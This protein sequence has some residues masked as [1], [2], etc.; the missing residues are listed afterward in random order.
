MKH[1]YSV[2]A[3]LALAPFTAVSAPSAP[4]AESPALLPKPNKLTV[5]TGPGFALTGALKVQA[6][7]GTVDSALIA[8]KG[9]LPAG[10]A[11]SETDKNSLSISVDPAL[12]KEAY[13]LT[14]TPDGLTLVAGDAAGA[15]YGAQTLIQ[16]VVKDSAGKPAI[17]AMT[18]EDRPRFAWRGLMLDSCRHFIKTSNVKRMIDVMAMYKFNTLHWHLT[19]DQGWR[20][21]IKKYPKLTEIGSV[22]TESPLIG[23]RNKGDGKPYGPFF[24]T[25]AE[26]KDIVAYAKAR[27]ITII[28]EIE[29]PGHA[30]AAIAAYPDLGNNDLPGFN[31]KLRTRWGVE[32]YVYA[33]KEET[34]KFLDDVIGEV[35]S[36]FPDAPYIHIGGDEC[37]K[38]QW[39]K[40]PFA[41]KVM[42]DNDLLT[43]GKPDPHKLQSWF[44]RRVEKSI[45]AHGKKL[46]GWDEIQEGGLSPTA[47]MMVWRD[48]KW[49]TEAIK[50]GNDVVMT[51]GTHCYLDHAPGNLPKDPAFET[52][53][54]SLTLE[55]V[56]S[57]NPVPAGLTPE[58]AK[59]VIGVQGN[60]WSEYIFNQPKLEFL[61]F[62]RAI[63]LAEVGWTSEGR[64]EADFKKRLEK[65][66]PRL[67]AMK[68]NYQKLDGT[69]AQPDAKIETE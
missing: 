40:S 57:M 69:P 65:N 64:D 36:L 25:Q 54:G 53:G 15:F 37:P 23:N 19:E 10:I 68:V 38:T 67:D 22:R 1:L 45:N 7:A 49:A 17:P 47:T 6:P 34:F 56:Y 60:L 66:L 51:P 3:L 43:D 35:A 8:L 61:A 2:A 58:E 42:T 27:Q 21:E 39:S 12:G 26:I 29:L 14:I 30:V 18:I 11:R 20:I 55:K 62:P 52:I 48:W 32:D 4:V 59:H 31:P 28:P 63:A 16:A 41:Q 13:N 44:I 50:H 24:Y 33:P 9:G 46:I 5:G